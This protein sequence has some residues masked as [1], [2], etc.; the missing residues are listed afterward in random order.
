MIHPHSFTYTWSY[1]PA[2]SCNYPHLTSPTLVLAGPSCLCLLGPFCSHSPTL[3]LATPPAHACSQMVV[4]VV[5][6]WWR[7][8]CSWYGGGGDDAATTKRWWWWCGQCGEVMWLLGRGGGG[9]HCPLLALAHLC[10]PSS[11]APV[12]TWL[13]TF[14]LGCVIVQSFAFVHACWH[15]NPIFSLHVIISIYYVLLVFFPM[16]LQQLKYQLKSLN[17]DL[18]DVLMWEWWRWREKVM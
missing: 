13:H 2:L 15:S 8:W 12:P 10:Q 4:V 16:I 18:S 9:A 6:W 17:N 3:A 5:E 1:S 14:K 7:Q 11:P